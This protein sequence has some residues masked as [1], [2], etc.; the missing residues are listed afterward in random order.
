[1]MYCIQERTCPRCAI[2]RTLNVFAW[3]SFCCNCKLQW[4]PQAA[5]PDTGLTRDWVDE[6]ISDVFANE[7]QLAGA[8]P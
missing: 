4:Y 5:S 3:G 2:K 6:L 7:P 1:M 8:A